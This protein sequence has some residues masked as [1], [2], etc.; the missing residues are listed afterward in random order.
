MACPLLRARQGTNTRWGYLGEQKPKV[1]RCIYELYLVWVA[2]PWGT[3]ATGTLS[4]QVSPALSSAPLYTANLSHP[5]ANI[6]NQQLFQGCFSP[7]LHL[8]SSNLPRRRIFLWRKM[9]Q[10]FHSLDFG[11]AECTVVTTWIVFLSRTRPQ[12]ACWYCHKR[13]FGEENHDKVSS[14]FSLRL[15]D[16]HSNKNLTK[17][18][19]SISFI[20]ADGELLGVGFKDLSSLLVQS[21]SDIVPSLGPLNDREKGEW[22]Q[23]YSAFLLKARI[24][25]F[26]VL[27]QTKILF[28]LCD[29]AFKWR[30][31]QT[32]EQCVPPRFPH[33]CLQRKNKQ[34]ELTWVSCSKQLRFLSWSSAT[35]Q[36]F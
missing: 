11:T 15:M 31:S 4:T 10:L 32:W 24:M 6:L 33:K 21:A 27:A 9:Q 14:C 18:N 17:Q 19:L 16:M 12:F 2:L 3:T 30:I 26:G 23:R 1:H 22:W 34:Q 28:Y 29:Y 13:Y 7:I 20:G 5:E 8:R 35:P 36:E 25:Y